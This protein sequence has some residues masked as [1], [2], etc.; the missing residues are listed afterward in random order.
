MT[1][2]TYTVVAHYKE[3]YY[4]TVDAYS[5]EEAKQIAI[6]NEADWQRVDDVFNHQPAVID[7]VIEE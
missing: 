7:E 5:K 3:K 2:K 6:D 1:K 4:Y